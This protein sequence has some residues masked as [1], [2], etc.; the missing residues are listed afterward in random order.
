MVLPW[1]CAARPDCLAIVNTSLN[2]RVCGAGNATKF[3][4]VFV[5]PGAGQDDTRAAFSQ[6]HHAPE[7]EGGTQEQDSVEVLSERE[8]ALEDD[9]ESE[10]EHVRDGSVAEGSLSDQGDGTE[11]DVAD[12]QALVRVEREVD[13]GQHEPETATT[14][15]ASREV[16]LGKAA[17]TGATPKRKVLETYARMEQQENLSRPKQA[18]LDRR[19]AC[20]GFNCYTET[21]RGT[22]V[23]CKRET[24]CYCVGCHMNCC[25]ADTTEEV[26]PI[27]YLS[28]ILPGTAGAK[29]VTLDTVKYT[30]HMHLHME[31]LLRHYGDEVVV[32]PL[33]S[34]DEVE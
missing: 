26:T 9:E 29:A 14:P 21:R 33:L 11:M 19:T 31:A 32:V 24:K 8:H 22:C 18:V 20:V 25:A 1:A 6:Q 28:I 12:E 2:C 34:K 4:R 17:V 3:K 10:P 13:V 23:F 7:E 5:R 30:C 15:E 27:K 16:R